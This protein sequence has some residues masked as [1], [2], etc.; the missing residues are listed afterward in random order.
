MIESFET[1]NEVSCSTMIWRYEGTTELS[2]ED[3]GG[4]DWN[5]D[6][7][8]LMTWQEDSWP[9]DL[10]GAIAVTSPIYRGSDPGRF[11]DTDILF[12]GYHFRWG[13]NGEWGRM[14]VAH[15]AT[16]EIGHAVGLDHSSIWGSTMYP[17]TS[18]GATDARS[19]HQDDINGLCSIYPAGSEDADPGDPC[20]EICEF[21]MDAYCVLF[22]GVKTCTHACDNANDCPDG[23]RC[24]NM[25]SVGPSCIVEGEGGQG[26][27][28]SAD[29]D[30]SKDLHCRNH[31]FESICTELCPADCELGYRCQETT[32]GD[33]ACMP[34][35]GSFGDACN[36]LLC[37]PPYVCANVA[38]GEFCSKTCTTYLDCPEA[39]IC[40]NWAQEKLC[41]EDEN[42][43]NA[44]LDDLVGQPASPVAAPTFVTF[45]AEAHSGNQVLYQFWLKSPDDD[46]R[47]VRDW[48]ASGSYK[49]MAAELGEFQ[50]RVRVIDSENAQSYD[51]Q[52]ELLYRVLDSEE[53]VD[54]DITADGDEADG[55][56]HTGGSGASSGGCQSHRTGPV[57]LWIMIVASL[58]WIRRNH[59]YS[60]FL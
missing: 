53:I 20:D 38:G 44:V 52:D 26:D 43:D 23:F 11:V 10:Q 16:H 19:L 45:T 39:T 60:S 55:D 1:W 29:W 47:M 57:W 35:V 49:W 50:I 46:W 37:E 27:T 8:N 22:Q 12:N 41:W 15:I 17:S 5:E 58:A 51:D 40:A 4:W 48:E 6:N 31:G 59:S 36:P 33:V 7:V 42:P 32:A 56:D 25:S 2:H 24:Q 30:C 54:G 9:R 14:D 3:W 18:E 13:V 21:D 28:C 34:E